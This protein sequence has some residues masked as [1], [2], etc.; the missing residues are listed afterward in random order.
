M[1]RKVVHTTAAPLFL[2]LWPFFTERPCARFFAAAVR[3]RQPNQS[4]RQYR[5]SSNSATHLP[6]RH[7]NLS[8][9]LCETSK[10][11]SSHVLTCTHARSRATR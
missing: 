10:D 4:G 2:V 8:H 7:S 3:I 9:F 5:N 11:V 6:A 1:S